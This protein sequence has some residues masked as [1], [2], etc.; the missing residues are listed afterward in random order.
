MWLR[1]WRDWSIFE[2]DGGIA[3]LAGNRRDAG[4]VHFHG[5]I[6]GSGLVCGGI[7]RQRRDAGFIHFHGGINL[8]HV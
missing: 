6:A 1:D 3:G 4:F 5:G 8:C 7:G 2:R